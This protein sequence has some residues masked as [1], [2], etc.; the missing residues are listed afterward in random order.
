MQSSEINVLALLGMYSFIFPVV[1]ARA[2]IRQLFERFVFIRNAQVFEFERAGAVIREA[3][4]ISTKS[5][6]EP[7]WGSGSAPGPAC[8]STPLDRQ[9]RDRWRFG[10]RR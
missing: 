1:F 9:G 2:G 8:L 6:G 5:A 4:I 7:A 10:K 3:E